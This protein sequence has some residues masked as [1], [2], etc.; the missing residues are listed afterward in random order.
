MYL[1]KRSLHKDHERQGHQQHGHDAKDGSS[2]QR[3]GPTALK[4]LSKR[5]G[6]F[7]DNADKDD[8]GDTV[9]DAACG[10][11]LTQPHQ[12]HSPAHKGDHT[13]RAEKQARIGHKTASLKA[14]SDTVGLHRRKDHGPVARVLVDLLTPLLTLF[15]EL[16]KLGNHRSHQL[17]DDRGR[18]VGHDPKGKDAHTGN[19]TAGEHVEHAPQASCGLV[20]ECAQFLCVD[21]GDRDIRPDTVDDQQSDREHDALAK[22]FGFA[23]CAP[24]HVRRHLLCSRCHAGPSFLIVTPQEG[25]PYPRRQ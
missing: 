8:K 19:R 21:T 22:L 14:H 9:A 25:R 7:S 6:Q 10:D 18:N 4:E 17:N 16:L 20:K 11:L 5:G 13:G 1:T 15:L 2:G 12:E 24:A 3:T 23:K